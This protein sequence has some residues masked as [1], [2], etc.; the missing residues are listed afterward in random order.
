[1]IAFLIL[2]QIVA[3][4][5]LIV[6]F[7]IAPPRNLLGVS[8]QALV[9]AIALLEIARMGV[10][11]FPPWWAPYLYGLLFMLAWDSLPKSNNF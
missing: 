8:L 11:V 6:W 7:E 5:A 1:M 10:W 9:T 4:L 3:P 2:V